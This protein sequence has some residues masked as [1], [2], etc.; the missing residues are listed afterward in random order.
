MLDQFSL[1]NFK[2]YI[3]ATSNLITPTIS[4]PTITMEEF[5]SKFALKEQVTMEVEVG[6]QGVPIM[7]EQVTMQQPAITIE[8]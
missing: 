8:M 2:K 6:E 1:S 5:Q 7:D 4:P 3:C